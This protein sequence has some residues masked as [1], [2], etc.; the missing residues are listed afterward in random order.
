MGLLQ[1]RAGGAAGGAQLASVVA[2]LMGAALAR[3]RPR[4]RLRIHF[5]LEPSAVVVTV[6]RRRP[7]R[8]Q[9]GAP[10]VESRAVTFDQSSTHGRRGGGRRASRN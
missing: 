3:A 2:D 7:G 6:E 9:P 10:F 5:D 4:D 1:H 8:L